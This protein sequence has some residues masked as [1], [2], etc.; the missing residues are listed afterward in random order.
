MLQGKNKE[1]W[2][3]KKNCITILDITDLDPI[4]K[5]S[6]TEEQ[7]R[8]GHKLFL[9]SVIIRVTYG[10]THSNLY[11]WK[12]FR[13]SMQ[14]I[15]KWGKLWQMQSARMCQARPKGRQSQDNAS[16]QAAW[17]TCTAWQRQR[18]RQRDIYTLYL[19]LSL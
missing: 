2:K 7:V 6:S 11:P 14:V 17:V 8:L 13:L 5:W 1:K 15:P 3:K 18:N 19:T 10:T 9:M 16:H 12:W 4:S